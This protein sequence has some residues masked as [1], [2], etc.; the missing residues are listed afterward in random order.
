[1]PDRFNQQDLAALLSHAWPPRGALGGASWAHGVARV[2]ARPDGQHD[3][4]GLSALREP[5]E[6]QAGIEEGVDQIGGSCIVAPSDEIVAA[7]TTK[8]DELALARCD[9]D[10]CNSFKDTT[11][12]FDVHRQ[13]DAYRRLVERRGPRPL[14]DGTPVKQAGDAT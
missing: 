8:G 12:N 1:M 14:A 6:G 7:C 5:F 11:F 10:L 4:G 13:P 3:R 9:L 2:L